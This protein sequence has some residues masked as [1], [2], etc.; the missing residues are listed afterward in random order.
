MNR[1]IRRASSHSSHAY[2][3]GTLIPSFAIVEIKYD[4]PGFDKVRDIYYT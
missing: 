2:V 3:P 4:G 1:H